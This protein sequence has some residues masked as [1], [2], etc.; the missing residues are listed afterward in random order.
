MR[1]LVFLGILRRFGAECRQFSCVYLCVRARLEL[2]AGVLDCEGYIF[3]IVACVL[4][5]CVLIHIHAYTH[6]HTHTHKRKHTFI[7]TFKYKQAFDHERVMK[8]FPIQ[9]DTYMHT[10]THIHTYIHTQTG[11]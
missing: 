7:N 4:C 2:C 11:I 9:F 5:V 1:A 8:K 3:A 6:I 10:H